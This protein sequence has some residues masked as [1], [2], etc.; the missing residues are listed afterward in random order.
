MHGNLMTKLTF[1]CSLSI[2]EQPD[3]IFVLAQPHLL[4]HFER[5]TESAIKNCSLME[6]I[7]ITNVVHEYDYQLRHQAIL[8]LATPATTR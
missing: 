7:F 8:W 2:F 6:A 3:F 1:Q 4:A 5:A